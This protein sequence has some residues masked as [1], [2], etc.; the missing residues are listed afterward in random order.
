M[1]KILDRFNDKY[2]ENK[3]KKTW[4]GLKSYGYNVLHLG[5]YPL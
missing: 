2:I 5:E 4:G 1:E 3:F